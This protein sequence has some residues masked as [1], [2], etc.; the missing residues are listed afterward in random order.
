MPISQKAIHR[1]LG[2]NEE[3]PLEPKEMAKLVNITFFPEEA[4][5]ISENVRAFGKKLRKSLQNLG[6]QIVPF[7]ETLVSV[8]FEKVVKRYL[9]ALINDFFVFPLRKLTGKKDEAQRTLGVLSQVRKGKRV[10]KGFSIIVSGES[11]T[12][13]LAMDYTMSFKKSMVITILDM[14][15]GID[16]NTGFVKHF[17]TALELFAYNMTNIVIGVDEKRWILY[18]F[19]GSHPIYPIDENF[20]YNVLHNLIPKI[21]APVRPPRLYEFKKRFEAFDIEDDFYRLFVDDLVRSGMLLEKT[22]LY[23]PGRTVDDLP[24]RNDFYRW[25]GKLHLDNRNGM[26]YGFLARQLPVE[27]S[28]VLTLEEAEN[29]FGQGVFK[30]K[31]YFVN[32]EGIFVLVQIDDKKLCVRVPDVWVLSQRSG[33]DK[34]HLNPKKD[35]VKLGLVSGYMVLETPIGLKLTKGY[36]PSF[37]SRIILSHAVANAIFGSVLNYLSPGCSFARRLEGSGMAL[38][39]WHGYIDPE[40]LPRGWFVHGQDNAPVSCSSPQAAVCAFSGKERSVKES[41]N[42][43]VDYQGDV[44][45]EPQ[46]G[47]NMSFP[48]LQGLGKL[49]SLHKDISKLGNQYWKFY[50]QD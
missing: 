48:S 19:N 34:M 15:P 49:L 41:L 43:K 50:K 27:L 33:S 14:P 6:V 21:A 13:N 47:T 36:R 42:G 39:H 25:V 35:I 29:R 37:D 8:P 10:M 22:G 7:Q 38:A 44:H 3:A 26:S 28:R 17:N 46:H 4:Q 23:P 32:Q 40:Q 20:E 12:G 1:I 18:N 2:I 45:I 9:L 30:E 11:K 24:F 16:E 5:E 31:D